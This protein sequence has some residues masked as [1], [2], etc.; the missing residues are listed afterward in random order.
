MITN[1]PAKN[2]G[3]FCPLLY[4]IYVCSV[5]SAGL[6]ASFFVIFREFLDKE[7]A[8]LDDCLKEQE[9]KVAQETIRVEK[10]E[11]EIE[12]IESEKKKVCHLQ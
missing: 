5:F 7:N 3:N 9:E 4:H 11:S 10:A 6:L 12:K 1:K 8:A 2:S